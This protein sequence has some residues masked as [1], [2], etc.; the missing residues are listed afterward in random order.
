MAIVDPNQVIPGQNI[1]PGQQPGPVSSGGAGVGGGQAKSTPGV[2]VP[3]QPSAQL[4]AYLSANQPQ[5]NQMAGQVAN[6]LAQNNSNAS[7]AIQP[8]VNAYSGNLYNVPTDNTVNKQVATSPSSLNPQ[9][10]QTFQTELQA[11]A[12]AP[13]PANTFETTL[14]YQDLTQNIQQNVEQANLWNS[15]NSIPNLS[16][17]LQPF[18]KSG[19]S[20][21]NTTLDALLLSQ[22]PMAYNQIQTAIKPAYNLQ[23]QL[24]AGTSQADAA[25]QNA[26]LQDQNTTT[27][28]TAAP[29]QFV[30][31]LNNTLAGYLAN[32]QGNANKY[33][34]SLNGLSGQ[35]AQL[36][37]QSTGWDN[38]IKDW[39]SWLAS[40]SGSPTHFD[41][42]TPVQNISPSQLPQ[43]IPLPTLSQVATN[44]N[45]SDIEALQN[46]IGDSQLGALNPAI[47]SS[48]ANQAGTYTPTSQ[49]P[50]IQDIY[51][52][53]IANAQG[54]LVKNLIALQ[55]DPFAYNQ[56][57][58][59]QEVIN[60]QNAYNTLAQYL[61]VGTMGGPATPPPGGVVATP[62]PQTP[63]PPQTS[64][65]YKGIVPLG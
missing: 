2:N 12:N 47:T 15:G 52:P 1:Q 45:Y 16:T 43:T 25:L 49:L 5:A 26:I 60:L 37:P 42:F 35:E 21:G 48:T 55:N 13:N 32:A 58:T 34:A 10:T 19:E 44:Q 53:V 54:A 62:P 6:T 59:V 17:A 65:G 20:S 14:P 64:P 41:Q 39:N 22:V 51:S 56:P 38:A 7:S 9:Q 30:S 57:Q 11:G 3:A 8:A 18:E 23:G 50:T 27:A 63:L 29:Q 46:L 40:T 31:G 4:S 61:G 28:A 36:Q 33:N 24:D